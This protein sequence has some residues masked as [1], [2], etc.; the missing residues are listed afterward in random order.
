VEEADALALRMVVWA[1]RR[2]VG[3]GGLARSFPGKAPTAHL[4]VFLE[5]AKAAATN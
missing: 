4:T 1:K 5:Q 2:N 3:L